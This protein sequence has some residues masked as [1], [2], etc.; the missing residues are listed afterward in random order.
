MTICLERGVL[1]W[2]CFKRFVFLLT[3][4][5]EAFTE[6]CWKESPVSVQVILFF[7]VLIE[8]RRN[9]AVLESS[10]T[11]FSSCLLLSACLLF[12]HFFL[13]IHQPLI[14]LWAIQLKLKE[15]QW[16][17]VFST[18]FLPALNYC[19]WSWW[20]LVWEFT[21]LFNNETADY[22]K[23]TSAGHYRWIEVKSVRET[24]SNH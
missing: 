20:F 19:A 2:V 18:P 9:D 22:E 1:R 15:R 13:P 23:A 6:R 7:I 8:R 14:F 3:V 24:N 12:A 5:D 16:P 10:R 21:S 4:R 17:F 11:I